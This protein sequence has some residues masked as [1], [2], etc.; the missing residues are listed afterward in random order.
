VG[1]VASASID[2][3]FGEIRVRDERGNELIVHGRVQPGDRPPTR[4]EQ[5]VLLEYDRERELFWV[6]PLGAEPGAAPGA[7]VPKQKQ[8]G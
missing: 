5:V 4:G 2:E 1:V 3:T 8:K 6:A 7:L